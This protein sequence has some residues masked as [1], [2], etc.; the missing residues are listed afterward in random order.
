MSGSHEARIS[1]TRQQYRE[2]H[3][4]FVARLS[5][6]SAA[7]AERASADGGWS[8]AQIGWHVAAVD[9]TFAALISGERPSLSLPDDFVERTW[10][11][12]AE[13]IPAKLQAGGPVVPPAAV[14]LADVLSA[15]DTASK[16][17][18]AALERLTPDRGARFGVTHKA[19]GTVSLYQ[20][21]EWAVAHTIRHN[22]QAKRV[23]GS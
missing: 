3:D 1:R 16:K 20:V 21:G 5:S 19:V 22:A 6:A 4:R 18:D 15:L 9:S 17:L 12:I 14:T 8:A 2:A 13:A 23:L 7:D 11:Q 10:D